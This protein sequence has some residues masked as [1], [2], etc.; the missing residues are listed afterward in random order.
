[1]EPE[2]DHQFFSDAEAPEETAVVKSKPEAGAGK[3]AKKQEQGPKKRYLVFIG[4]LPYTIEKGDLEKLFKDIGIQMQC[5]GFTFICYIEVMSIRLLSD[6]VTGKPRGIAFA[7]F[8]DA[9]NME[10]STFF[11]TCTYFLCRKHWLCIRLK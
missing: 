8:P 1:M 2:V 6:K 11:L 9:E 3:R 5:F 10:V 7:E 4:N